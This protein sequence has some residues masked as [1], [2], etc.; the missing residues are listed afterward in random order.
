MPDEP[1]DK[2]KQASA[3]EKPRTGPLDLIKKHRV[4][5]A[6]GALVVIVAIIGGVLWWL[7]AR[8][9]ET[10]DDATVDTAL[11]H[12]APLAI[13]RV[14]E[15][16]VVPNQQ[17]AAGALLLRL[18]PAPGA[19]AS[20]DGEVRAPV[21]GQVAH[22]TAA[23]GSTVMPGQQ[24]MTIVPDQFWITANFKET[25]LADMRAGQVATVTLDAYPGQTFP[26]HVESFEAGAGQAFALLPPDNA[27]GN[28]V[29]STQRVAVRIVFDQPPRALPTLGPGMSANGSVKVR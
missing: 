27:S 5:A 3:E 24:L 26:A 8:H 12:I 14:A 19:G 10:T 23:R 6:I 13:G 9:Y 16:D 21:A 2:D 18:D 25:Q 29:K 7:D 22:L 20:A 11:V 28:F 4:L 1:A 17:V 15:L